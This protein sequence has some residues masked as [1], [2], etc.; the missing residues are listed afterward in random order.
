MDHSTVQNTTA[1]NLNG[2]LQSDRLQAH[3]A[4][5]ELDSLLRSLCFCSWNQFLDLKEKLIGQWSAA[6]IV[7]HS[8]GL[9]NESHDKY[10]FLICVLDPCFTS[11]WQA[12]D[13][14]EQSRFLKNIFLS[15]KVKDM[16]LGA[17]GAAL[18]CVR[19][20]ELAGSDM[21]MSVKARLSACETRMLDFVL[22]IL[23]QNPQLESLI[24][25]FL[26]MNVEGY[27]GH[28]SINRARQGLRIM[29]RN[30]GTR[31]LLKRLAS[32]SEDQVKMAVVLLGRVKNPNVVPHLLK[33]YDE[34]GEQ[35][36]DLAV[37][38]LLHY[39]INVADLRTG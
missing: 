3:Q 16:R 35:L 1:I 23:V 24:F 4:G 33:V 28:L 18:Q 14:I 32:D 20:K 29:A 36:R 11:D 6:S 13:Q 21:S 8:L 22:D 30:A 38:A 25:E 27:C 19:Q 9:L 7:S 12:N 26:L 34:S 15:S 10:Q 17:L 5:D 2:A 39:S 37:E 31:S